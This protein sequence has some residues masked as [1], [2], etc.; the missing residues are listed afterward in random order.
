MDQ[1]TEKREERRVA[2]EN[3]DILNLVTTINPSDITD[4][5]KAM[6]TR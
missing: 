3:R 1:S 4:T 5:Q 2:Q 6:V